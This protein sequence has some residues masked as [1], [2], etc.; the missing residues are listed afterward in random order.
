LFVFNNFS[1]SFGKKYFFAKAAG[2][3]GTGMVVGV[4]E[5]SLSVTIRLCVAAS[6][7]AAMKFRARGIAAL[8][9]RL[10]FIRLRG[11]EVSWKSL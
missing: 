10:F 7:R 5:E 8:G 2:S 9:F 1:G 11:I 3:P 6:V 4:P